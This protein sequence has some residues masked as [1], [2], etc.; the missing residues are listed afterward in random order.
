MP[1]LSPRLPTDHPSLFR[2]SAPCFV[3]LSTTGFGLGFG[4]VHSAS[5]TV[6]MNSRVRDTL[7]EHRRRKFSGLDALTV[8]GSRIMDQADFISAPATSYATVGAHTVT[9]ASFD[10][11]FASGQLMVD[12][13]ANAAAYGPDASAT[14]ILEGKV[15]VPAEMQPL[16]GELAEI[17]HSVER[18]SAAPSL[19]RSS[20]D[21]A[22]LGEF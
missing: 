13:E 4:R 18:V 9:G 12:G 8:C 14:S 22:T 1:T 19:T 2:W 16:Y 10:L 3:K 15:D 11:S 20:L 17:V 21:R 7:E 5:F 6:C